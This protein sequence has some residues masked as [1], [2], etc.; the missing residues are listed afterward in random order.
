MDISRVKPSEAM[1]DILHPG[2]GEQLGITVGC[3]SLDD[4]QMKKIK[5]KINDERIHLEKRGKTFDSAKIDENASVLL[6]SAMTGWEW[7]KDQ[8]GEQVTFNGEIPP[9]NKSNVLKVFDELPWFRD[10]V[11]EKVGETKSFF[12]S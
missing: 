5:R 6:F 3:L 2:T 9:F 1:L 12:Q 10:Q 8:S 7:G 4:E 11:L